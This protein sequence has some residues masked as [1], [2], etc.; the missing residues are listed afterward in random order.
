MRIL[1]I[2]DEDIARAARALREGL[3]VAFPTETVYGLGADAFNPT[4]L[5]R[6]FRAKKRPRFDPLIIHIAALEGLDP[7]AD[8]DALEGERR[9]QVR[10][11]CRRLWPGPLTLILP[12]RGAVPDLA[13]AGL[14]TVAVRFPDHG[15][16][17]RLIALSTGAVAA[18]SANPFGRLSPTRAEHVRD[19]LGDR[20][21]L[22][23]DGGRTRVG[24]ESTVL[25]MTGPVP[26]LLRPGGCPQGEIEALIGP[27]DI[28]GG[29]PVNAPGQL[30]SHYAPRTPL[31]LRG[32]E[33][34]AAPDYEA[35]AGYLFFSGASRERWSRRLPAGGPAPLTRV[36]SEKGDGVE[37]AANLF[38]TLHELD[39]RGLSR[40]HAEEAPPEGLGPAINDR[41]RK[42]AA[43]GAS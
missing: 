30:K 17:L 35:G 21:D 10:R 39:R 18:P 26:R 8:L 20:V 28:S 6:V 12:K 37:A 7:L 40:I 5:A 38:D 2:S 4:A 9:D 32:P 43:A 25:D 15:A 19:Q 11:L 23:L 41:L 1:S 29:G 33:E 36:L 42:A 34:M 3:L 31:T 22:I 14:P 27:V 13:T 24:L 16:A